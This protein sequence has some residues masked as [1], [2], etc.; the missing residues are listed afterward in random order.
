MKVLQR[1]LHY[2]H[3]VLGLVLCIAGAWTIYSFLL[4]SEYRVI[5]DSAFAYEVQ[6]RIRALAVHKNASELYIQLKKEIPLVSAVSIAYR[7]S[8]QALVSVKAEQPRLLIEPLAHEIA[9]SYV[10]T[11][12]G[13]LIEKRFF[14]EEILEYMPVV[15]KE[16][17][18][19]EQLKNPQICAS[20]LAI[21]PE[22]FENY[23]ILWRSKNEIILYST[24]YH[25]LTLIA[26]NSSIHQKEKFAYAESI[27]ERRHEQ[28][29]KG[30]K[31]DIRLRGS[32]VCGPPGGG[33]DYEK[34]VTV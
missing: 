6:E 33:I 26:D 7:G 3:Y 4:P 1:V 23:A 19:L 8:R 14:N 10:V 15:R 12:S 17:A 25:D 20:L 9:P 31:I 18:A 27:Y 29:E 30:I 21:R 2:S 24:R 28:Y 13:N 16:T 34:S 22:V 5:C 32:V 11:A